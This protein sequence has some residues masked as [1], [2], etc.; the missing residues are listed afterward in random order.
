MLAISSGLTTLDLIKNEDINKLLNDS[1]AKINKISNAIDKVYS[2]SVSS[3]IKPKRQA[4]LVGLYLSSLLEQ[5]WSR[6]MNMQPH[7]IDN[8]FTMIRLIDKC[9]K[10]IPGNQKIEDIS[11]RYCEEL[12]ADAQIEIQLGREG[13]AQELI[14]LK[15]WLKPPIK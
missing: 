9:A 7:G 14:Q 11:N 5:E 10:M 6:A 4:D 15:N 12:E 8:L 2:P 3:K 13:S 1:A